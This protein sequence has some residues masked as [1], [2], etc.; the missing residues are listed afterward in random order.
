M[1]IVVLLIGLLLPA[2]LLHE[3]MPGRDRS[4]QALGSLVLT[5]GSWICFYYLIA[6]L[7]VPAGLAAVLMVLVLV[8]WSF[9]TGI[10]V[11]RTTVVAGLLAGVCV[12]PY[13]IGYLFSGMLPGCDTAMHGYITRLIMEQQGLPA[14]YRPLLPV[15]EFGAYSAGFHFIAACCACFQPHWLMEGL[16]AATVVSHLVA[17]I[18]LAFL[19]TLFAPARTAVVVAMI[20]FWFHRGLQTVVDWGGTPTVLSLGLMCGAMAFFGYAIRERSY[21]YAIMGSTLWSAAALTHLIPA[22]AGFYLTAGLVAYWILTY[23]PRPLFVLGSV[24]V[25]AATALVLMAP[26]ALRMNTARPPALLH[27]IHEWQRHMMRD[28]ITGRLRDD[29]FRLLGEVKFN[30]SDLTMIAVAACV[31]WMILR[32]R[33]T[34]L[35]WFMGVSILLFALV[36]NTGT[37]FLPWSE[38]LYPERVMYF[39]VV[40]CGILLCWA[41]E[42]LT[43]F[44]PAKQYR[45]LPI[46]GLLALAIACSNCFQRYVTAVADSGRRY[47]AGMREGFQWIN[48][49]TAPDAVIHVAYDTEGMW[50]PA[51]SYR[52]A[53]GTHLHFIHEVAGV[54]H[55]LDALPVDHYELWVNGRTTTVAVKD[56]L[57]EMRRIVFKNEAVELVQT[58][59]RR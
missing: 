50:V 20:V 58:R 23:R 36:V 27:R 3:R 46:V 15:D 37:W 7:R 22:Y 25:A 33:F 18:G 4:T 52:A 30:L 40:P 55:T 49:Q 1:P 9:R 10:T 29:L 59:K 8:A 19:L 38:L 41:A 26:F 44:Q 54:A 14:S 39:F 11:P 42:D 53:V 2:L 12:L 47:D 5:V 32:R 56:T 21:R 24:G 6:I 17:I 28:V 35:G 48:D 16:S 45:I 34:K 57:A 51:L 13:A 43:A 31:L